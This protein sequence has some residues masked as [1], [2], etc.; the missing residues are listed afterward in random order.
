MPV[1]DWIKERTNAEHKR[2]IKDR[3]PE[4]WQFHLRVNDADL[5][6]GHPPTD[7]QIVLLVSHRQRV[8]GGQKKSGQQVRTHSDSWLQV[9]IP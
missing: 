3:T 6:I 8:G 2:G 4:E 7:S 1:V 5:R 9:L